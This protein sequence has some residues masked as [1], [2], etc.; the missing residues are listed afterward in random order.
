MRYAPTPHACYVYAADT[1]AAMPLPPLF[2]ATRCCL[3]AFYAAID[4]AD[5]CHFAFF[6]TLLFSLLPM[7]PLLP[8]LLMLPLSDIFLMPIITHAVA[9]S[10][11]ATLPMPLPFFADAA[12]ADTLR[13]AFAASFFTIFAII[14]IS[15]PF[16][17]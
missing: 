1:A 2:R 15:T 9:A 5:Y 11:S 8:P 10:L 12:D 7:R 3:L 17:A 6:F 16:A 13:Y 14:F 4:A